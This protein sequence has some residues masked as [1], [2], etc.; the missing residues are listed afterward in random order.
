[1]ILLFLNHRPLLFQCSLTLQ[2]SQ[3]FLTHLFL[4]LHR[5]SQ[6]SQKRRKKKNWKKP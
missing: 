6:K 3:C 1:M 4:H 2:K 5:K